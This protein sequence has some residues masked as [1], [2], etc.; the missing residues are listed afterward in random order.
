MSDFHNY[1]ASDLQTSLEHMTDE[2]DKAERGRQY[3]IAKCADL[4][5]ELEQYKA[6]AERLAKVVYAAGC[7]TYPTY[8]DYQKLVNGGN[9]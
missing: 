9:R 4:E 3:M 1:V 2:R 8:T 6:I 7:Y 5:N